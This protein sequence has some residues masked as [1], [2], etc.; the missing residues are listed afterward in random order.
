[1]QAHAAEQPKIA[2][3]IIALEELIKSHVKII[4]ELKEEKRQKLDM[5]NDSYKGDS[6]Y[7]DL[8]E[9]A[10][11]ARKKA[12]ELKKQILAT[13]QHLSNEIDEL[14]SDLKEKQAALSE[15]LLEYK[16]ISGFTQLELF[17]GVVG[18]IVLSAKLIRA[19]RI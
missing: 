6:A 15:Y 3:T 9:N 13:K 4:M 18:E 5:L 8:D 14:K 19:K 11:A 10:K 16:R 7:K 2:D 17:D 1:M 12:Q